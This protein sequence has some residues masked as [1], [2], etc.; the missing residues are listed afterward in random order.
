VPKQ[1]RLWLYQ[2]DVDRASSAQGG[3]AQ[4]VM[5]PGDMF[6]GDRIAEVHD[7]GKPVGAGEH[8]KT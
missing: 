2:E 4:G 3:R 5:P 8:V 1:A 6:W 7:A